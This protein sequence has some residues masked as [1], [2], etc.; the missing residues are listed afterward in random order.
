MEQKRD[1]VELSFATY[2][3]S[4]HLRSL[5]KQEDGETHMMIPLL[6]ILGGLLIL[7]GLGGVFAAFFVSPRR[8]YMIKR[9]RT[10]TTYYNQPTKNNENEHTSDA[11]FKR[12]N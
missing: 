3:T 8:L 2:N 7:A 5:E 4:E 9:S 10:R 1:L 6:N 12:I 11:A